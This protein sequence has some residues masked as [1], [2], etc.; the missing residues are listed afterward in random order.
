MK[1]SGASGVTMELTSGP[2]RDRDPDAAPGSRGELRLLVRDDGRGGAV[3]GAGS[4]LTGLR[5]RVRTVDGTLTCDSPP[6]GPTV[7]TV[8]VPRA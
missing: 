4:G 8:R 6:G 7:V 2:G 3:I 1:H 5:A